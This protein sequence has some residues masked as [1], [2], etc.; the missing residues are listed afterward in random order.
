M[1]EYILKLIFINILIWFSIFFYFEN[2][3]KI[4][5]TVTMKKKTK[6]NK[7]DKKNKWCYNKNSLKSL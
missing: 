5:I 6:K 7:I 2:F 3:I 4:T 1:N